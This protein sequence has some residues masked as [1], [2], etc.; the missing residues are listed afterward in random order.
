[1]T[2]FYPDDIQQ[3][4][5]I[6][7]VYITDFKIL[8]RPVEI[9]GKNPIL[10]KDISFTDEIRLS[11]KHTVFSFEFVA[12]NYAI[13]SQNQYAYQL[14]GFDEDWNYINNRRFVSYTNLD[15][16]EYTFKV[17]A[18]NNDGCWNEA[19]AKI[20]IT[21]SPPFWRTLWFKILIIALLLL[22][23]KHF[24]DDLRQKKNLSEATALANEAQLKLL[25]N[26]MN[27][28]FLF[29]ALGSIRSMILINVESAWDMVSE[30]SEFFR[31]T[32]LNFNKVKALLDDEINAVNNYLHIEKI[33]YKDSLQVSFKIDE[34]ARKCLVPA[35]ICQP[36]I[37]NS[38]K[39]GMLTSPMPLKVDI[40]I[41]NQDNLLSIDVSNTGQ[42]KE[43][44]VN[45]AEKSE[46]H[47]TSLENIKQRLGIMFHDQYRFQLFEKDGWV[48][49]K[50]LIRYEEK[51]K[52]KSLVLKE[53]SFIDA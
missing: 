13:S 42:L 33:R 9:G 12:L 24:F 50:I 40:S 32:L 20:K 35:F 48:H 52:D 26:Q 37:E 39:Y 30:L 8:N 10:T 17:K 2:A 49:A 45:A 22:I 46:V 34:A 43:S 47:G 28:H 15:P 21:I 18:A 3:N 29:N 14:V 31:Y 53:S 25:R 1:V 51:R 19:G 23:I 38:I 7:P 16:G 4:T 44:T 11:Y 5:Y 27:P 36:L 6:P 41:S